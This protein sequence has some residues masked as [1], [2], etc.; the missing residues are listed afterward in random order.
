[1]AYLVLDLDD[2]TKTS[3]PDADHTPAAI[4]MER[5]ILIEYANTSVHRS[6]EIVMGDVNFPF[7]VHAEPLIFIFQQQASDELMNWQ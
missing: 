4:A 2:G 5:I 6:A 3:C 7:A 1:M